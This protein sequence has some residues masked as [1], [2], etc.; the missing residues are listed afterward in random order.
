M[1]CFL[2]AVTKVP[3]GAFSALTQLVGQHEGHPVRKKYGGM[4]EMGTG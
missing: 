4:V 2:L 3:E 1:S